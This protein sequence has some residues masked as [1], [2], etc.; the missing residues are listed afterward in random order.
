MSDHSHDKPLANPFAPHPWPL[1]RLAAHY[2][3]SISQLLWIILEEQLPVLVYVDRH[4][5][6]IGTMSDPINEWVELNRDSLKPFAF[7]VAYQAGP[8]L[9]SFKRLCGETVE[10]S[11]LG[12]C[13]RWDALYLTS[14]GIKALHSAIAR[15]WPTISKA[16]TEEHSGGSPYKQ[17]KQRTTHHAELKIMLGFSEFWRDRSPAERKELLRA[18]RLNVAEVARRLCLS[19]NQHYLPDGPDRKRIQNVLSKHRSELKL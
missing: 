8:H 3:Y 2:S 16:S 18:G 14:S 13:L 19:K 15:S 6:R 4:I 7:N 9:E 11:R 1:S 12:H 5:T 17:T 10:G